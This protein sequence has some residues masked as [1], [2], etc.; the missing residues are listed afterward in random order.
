MR[1][2]PWLAED[3]EL[4]LYFTHDGVD[5][6]LIRLSGDPDSTPFPRGSRPDVRAVRGIDHLPDMAS[7]EIEMLGD[8][9]NRGRGFAIH[10]R[11]H[12]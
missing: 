10:A 12:T 4:L 7:G 3:S 8:F 11:I 1:Q 2:Q 5:I 9:E 6:D